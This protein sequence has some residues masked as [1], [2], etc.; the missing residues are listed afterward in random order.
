MQSLQ[1]G[2]LAIEKEN[3]YLFVVFMLIG[4]V[5]L[6]IHPLIKWLV[7]HQS[8]KLLCYMFC[9]L[10]VLLLF[11][12]TVLFAGVQDLAIILLK[13]LLQGIALFG[14]ILFLLYSTRYLMKGRRKQKRV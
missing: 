6:M 2:M 10:F 12:L 11:F 13:V 8:V 3:M 9:S 5:F 4:M 1:I 14:G 7:R